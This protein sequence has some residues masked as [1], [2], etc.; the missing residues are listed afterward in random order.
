MQNPRNVYAILPILGERFS[1]GTASFEQKKRLA[2]P[3]RADKTLIVFFAMS[4]PFW[5]AGATEPPNG[6][7]SF[8]GRRL[9]YRR[10]G[11]NDPYV[12]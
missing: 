8:T 3:F 7:S 6:Y 12:P 2:R 9:R 10:H 11:C 4:L 1:K 5:G